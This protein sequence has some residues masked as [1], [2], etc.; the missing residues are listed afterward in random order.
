[1]QS[2]IE[3]RV[4]INP[5]LRRGIP[6][7]GRGRKCRLWNWLV[8]IPPLVVGGVRGTYEMFP[9]DSL[10]TF[11]SVRKYEHS[12][13]TASDLAIAR[14]PSHQGEGFRLPR[15]AFALLAMTWGDRRA[16]SSILNSQFSIL[17]SQFSILNFQLSILYCVIFTAERCSLCRIFM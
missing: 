11:S 5:S 4:E 3:L 16:V 15:R 10:H 9:G 2:T 8:P 17:N 12:P 14:P 1:M 13:N 6:Q 7:G